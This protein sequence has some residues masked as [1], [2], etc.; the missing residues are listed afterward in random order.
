MCDSPGGFT[1]AVVAIV[2]VTAIARQALRIIESKRA[3]VY[4]KSEQVT[5]DTTT[6][7]IATRRN[8]NWVRLI[9]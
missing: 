7:A 5:P 4:S 9:A 6:A 8:R 1:V 3:T 2:V